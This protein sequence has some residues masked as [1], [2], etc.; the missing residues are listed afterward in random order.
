MHGRFTVG[1]AA[2]AILVSAL[3]LSGCAGLQDSWGE[4]TY[5]VEPLGDGGDLPAY[6]AP[7]LVDRVQD[8]R[9]RISIED[10][11]PTKYC[12]E[13]EG[14]ERCS[15]YNEWQHIKTL[16]AHEGHTYTPAMDQAHAAWRSAGLEAS[17]IDLP[18]LEPL[19]DLRL[20]RELDHSVKRQRWG[21]TPESRIAVQALATLGIDVLVLRISTLECPGCATHVLN[22]RAGEPSSAP[23]EDVDGLESMLSQIESNPLSVLR[24]NRWHDKPQDF[25]S[26]EQRGGLLFVDPPSGALLAFCDYSHD[27][28]FRGLRRP[29]GDVSVAEWDAAPTAEHQAVLSELFAARIKGSF[30]TACGPLLRRLSASAGAAG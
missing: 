24:G 10:L 25:Q 23:T 13:Y 9:L 4:L 5:P 14:E 22:V 17:S 30:E 21:L 2:W 12:Y 26:L 20:V 27:S 11:R 6:K 18:L 28:G 1:H 29:I 8:H 19:Y 3:A 15:T 16:A 7:V